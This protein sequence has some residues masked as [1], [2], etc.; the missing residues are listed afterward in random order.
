MPK[1]V[2]CK[3]RKMQTTIK[4]NKHQRNMKK[5]Q[6]FLKANDMSE[7]FIAFVHKKEKKIA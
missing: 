3:T 4:S 6:E 2:S 7:V 1:S 5:L